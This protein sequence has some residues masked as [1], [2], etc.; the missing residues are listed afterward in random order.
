M[1][2]FRKAWLRKS[3][4]F[5]TTVLLALLGFGLNVVAGAHAAAV[6]VSG[7]SSCTEV[8]LMSSKPPVQES[9]SRT[10]STPPRGS[11]VLLWSMRL[12]PVPPLRQAS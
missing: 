3:A 11:K 10:A 4:C 6:D 7:T 2:L 1:K 9:P 5:L 12:G 8:I